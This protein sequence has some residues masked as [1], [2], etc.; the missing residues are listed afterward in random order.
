MQ[1]AEGEKQMEPARNKTD[2]DGM[3]GNICVR[4]LWKGE[5]EPDAEFMHLK[6]ADPLE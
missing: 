5:N 2:V 6:D 1:M 4:D 3:E